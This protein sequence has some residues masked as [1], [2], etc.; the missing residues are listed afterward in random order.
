MLAILSSTVPDVQT[1]LE[2]NHCDAWDISRSDL[3]GTFFEDF[4]ATFTISD[5]FKFVT[6]KVEKRE[7][8]KQLENRKLFSINQTMDLLFCQKKHVLF[9]FH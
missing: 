3:G 4:F 1:D 7:E 5:P 8:L 6:E 9:T 2:G